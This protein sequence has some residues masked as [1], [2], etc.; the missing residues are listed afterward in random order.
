[1]KSST[2]SPLWRTRRAARITERLND[3]P[4]GNN[5][6][7]R[8]ESKQKGQISAVTL[9]DELVRAF[10]QVSVNFSEL[11]ETLIYHTALLISPH[12]VHI[13]Y[14]TLAGLGFTTVEKIFRALVI[15]RTSAR[16]VKSTSSFQAHVDEIRRRLNAV[17]GSIAKAR[18]GRNDYIHSHWNPAYVF[19]EN[20]EHY[21]ESGEANL[22]RHKMHDRRGYELAMTTCSVDEIGALAV[23]IERAMFDLVD[24]VIWSN[25]VLTPAD[26]LF[27][28]NE[29]FQPA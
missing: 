16:F 18:E 13:G 6:T 3:L 17:M 14:V 15:E 9:D 26:A 27:P 28:K 23:Q 4:P 7:S 5:M 12:D 2:D 24:F 19:D 8:N 25:G 21:I 11:E 22:T 10:G 29:G 20:I 1:M